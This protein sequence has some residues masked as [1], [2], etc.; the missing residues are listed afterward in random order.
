M[1]DSDRCPGTNRE[2]EQCGHP[3]GWGTDNETG[4]CKFHGGASDNTGNQHARKHGLHSTPEYLLT[5]LSER[6]LDT[7]YATHEALCTRFEEV[8]NYEPDFAAKKRLSRLAVEIV[9]EDLVDEYLRD[10]A[11]GHPLVETQEIFDEGTGMVHEIE[12]P[13][14]LL[15]QMTQL[16]RETRLTMKDLGLLN[17]PETQQAAA[18]QNLFVKLAEA[19][20]GSNE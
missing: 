9:K 13:N 12:V 3:E 18:Q 6:H 17:D 10:Q 8:H 1:N 14:K 2:G 19:V 5:D 16:K 11:D 4:P 20:H 15:S 7:Y